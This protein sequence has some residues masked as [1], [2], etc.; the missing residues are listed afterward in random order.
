M[1]DN[2]IKLSQEIVANIAKIDRFQGLW[3]GG[4]RFSPQILSR[5]KAWAIIS[6]TGASTR[7]EGAKMEDEEI[8]RF[9]RGLKTTPPKNRDEQEVAGYADLIGRI[10]DNHQ[11][12][13]LSENW[14][15]QFHSILL[16][17]SA[18][19]KEH[20][21]H[22]K[23]RENTVALV[24]PD[25]QMVVLFKPTPPYLVKPEMGVAVDWANNHFL[26]GDIHPILVIAN[27]IFE[28]LAIHPFTDGNGRLSR[29]LTNLLLLR[30]G[31]DYIPY[32]SLDE[33]IEG[34]R[35]EYYL[36]LRASQKNHK[37][38]HENIN[39]WVDYFLGALVE[40][41]NRARQLI[42]NEQPEKLLSEKQ[43][44]VLNLFEDNKTLS[45]ADVSGLLKN[46]MPLVSIKQ[47]LS[48]LLGHKLLE[49]IGQGRGTRYRKVQ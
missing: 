34:T 47:V 20:K 28:F 17:F 43:A 40:Q 2:R 4:A 24:K 12:I 8:A 5:L 3:Q 23:T 10:F 39:P 26:S 29:A 33:I 35:T 22:Y 49:R 44:Q 27:F 15:L 46:E 9:L 7:I 31:Y 36:A 6:S 30:S 16:Q 32:V 13:K 1:L 38:K 48:R 21:G 19:D 25:G 18:K 37:T 11:S 14:I 41:T 42:D 45:V